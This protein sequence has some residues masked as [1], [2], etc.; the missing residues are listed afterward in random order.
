MS[1]KLTYL[2]LL[3]AC[4]AGQT[5][6][7]VTVGNASKLCDY[8]KVVYSI[9]RDGKTISSGD[10][11]KF[12][13]DSKLTIQRVRIEE[14]DTADGKRIKYKANVKESTNPDYFEFLGYLNEQWL[15]SIPALTQEIQNRIYSS[16]ANSK[17]LA[18]G[19]CNNLVCTQFKVA[20]KGSAPGAMKTEV[21]V[22]DDALSSIIVDTAI[23]KFTFIKS[24]KDKMK[25]KFFTITE[26][27]DGTK[28]VNALVM[29]E[30]HPNTPDQV[31]TGGTK[32]WGEVTSNGSNYTQAH[33]FRLKLSFGWG[34]V[35]LGEG[36]EDEF[37][38]H[39]SAETD[40]FIGASTSNK[41]DNF[42]DDNDLPTS[43]SQRQSSR[44]NVRGPARRNDDDQDD[45]LPPQRQL[46]KKTQQIKP[47]QV[48]Q[49]YDDDNVEEDQGDDYVEEQEQQLP[50]SRQQS[51]QQP[52][53]KGKPQMKT[54]QQP[55][56]QTNRRQ[57]Q[58]E[59]YED[60]DNNEE[61]YS[62]EEQV[63]ELPKGRRTRR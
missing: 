33:G 4:R 20:P 62:D 5:V 2:D 23:N 31:I 39:N 44:S 24:R 27:E 13:E 53:P 36:I 57:Q 15:A 30:K 1:V 38:A 41:K 35:E 14:N 52:L 48:T 37:S 9:E 28:K 25:S 3:E 56:K 54:T 29:S 17:K 34:Y 8:L 60:D 63:E 32:Y 46:T 7:N 47:K 10:S 26:S 42:V 40:E 43:K 22:L 19:D 45:N 12:P 6:L 16:D 21:K 51:R 61:Q 55:P 58:E 50:K 11:F 59:T 49:R 18:Y